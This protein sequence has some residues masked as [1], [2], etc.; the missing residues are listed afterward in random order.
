MTNEQ[1]ITMKQNTLICLSASTLLSVVIS[2][3]W[4]GQKFE[5]IDARIK[6]SVT[7]T[8]MHK[9]EAKFVEMNPPMRAAGIFNFHEY[10][11]E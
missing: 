11:R 8:E 10:E 9:W 1:K 2:A 4:F 7:V 6:A 5:R 3:F